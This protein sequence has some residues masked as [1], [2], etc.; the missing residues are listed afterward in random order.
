MTVPGWSVEH[1]RG[2]AQELHDRGL[3]D[4]TRPAV[5]IQSPARRALVL[6]ASQ[7]HDLIDEARAAARGIEVCRR[8]SGGGIVLVDPAESVWIDIVVPIDG[9]GAMSDPGPLSRWVG[10]AWL[11]ALRHLRIDE[12][13][14]HGGRSTDRERAGLLCFAGLGPGEVLQ[15]TP[16]GPSKVVGLSQRRTRTVARVQGLFVTRWDPAVLREVVRPDAWPSDLDPADVRAGVRTGGLPAHREVVDA[17]LTSLGDTSWLG[18][19]TLV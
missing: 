1:C 19:G 5:W 17:V 8:R 3:G 6:G 9:R 11:R 4:V 15:R 13:E 16:E 7:T 2:T 12:L 18:G 10:A 14:V